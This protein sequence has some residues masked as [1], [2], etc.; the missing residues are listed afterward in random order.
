[1]VPQTSNLP[2][3][4]VLDEF[5]FLAPRQSRAGF[6]GAGCATRPEDV[7]ASVQDATG[8]ALKALQAVV[9]SAHHG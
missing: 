5:Q 9:R 3:G 7:S 8:A 1:M 4:F 6:H 2:A